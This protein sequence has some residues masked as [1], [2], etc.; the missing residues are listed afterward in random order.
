[1]FAVVHQLRIISHLV[2]NVPSLSNKEKDIGI[3]ARFLQARCSSCRCHGSAGG[4]LAAMLV[5]RFEAISVSL[6][7]RSA[8]C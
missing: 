5:S 1:M 4:R 2:L 7:R 6:S 8:D 3:L